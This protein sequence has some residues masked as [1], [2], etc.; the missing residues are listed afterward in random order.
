MR[1]A[2]DM[3]EGPL[4]QVARE[5]TRE[6]TASPW[7]KE[8]AMVLAKELDVMA[9]QPAPIPS[10]LIG[11]WRDVMKEVEAGSNRDE[12]EG[13]DPIDRFLEAA[14]AGGMEGQAPPPTPN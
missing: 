6:S 10:G 3:I 11:Q 9:L 1:D 4:T 7:V 8:T 2:L 5:L 14:L 13:G 12:A